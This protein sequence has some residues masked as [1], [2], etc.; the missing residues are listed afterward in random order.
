MP[1]YE[2]VAEADDGDSIVE[3]AAALKPDV[4]LMDIEMPNTDG[5]EATRQ[6]TAKTGGAVKVIVLSFHTEEEFVAEAFRAG[7]SGYLCK[8][9]GFAE[10]VM[11]LQEVG[12]GRKYLCPTVTSPV[13]ARY[14]APGKDGP[15]RADLTPRERQVLKM[16]SDGLSVKRIAAILDLSVKT[17]FAARSNVM[18]KIGATSTADLTKYAL[19]H[20]LVTLDRRDRHHASVGLGPHSSSPPGRTGARTV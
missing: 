14:V 9:S 18:A 20:G 10:L 6:I 7:A 16:L 17:V 15:P 5:I 13:I 2:V 1:E 3:L 4:I 19:R 12:K 8:E 11:A